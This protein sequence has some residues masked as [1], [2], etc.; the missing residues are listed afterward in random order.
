MP[1]SAENFPMAC[2]NS[3][4]P[5]ILDI[6][7]IHHAWSLALH[8]SLNEATNYGAGLHKFHVFC[9]TFSIP[10][11]DCLPAAFPLL[12]SFAIWAVTD[13]DLEDAM[14]A[15]GMVFKTVSIPTVCK[16]LAAICAWHLVQ[17]WPPPLSEIERE[18]LEFSLRGMAHR[19]G[20]S[21]K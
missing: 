15:D 14:F 20:V 8:S 12:H 13:P 21:Q 17:S 6:P 2:I 9:D 5:A 11:S 10:E 1:F 19:Q 16:Y 18:R 7:I 3:P 4:P